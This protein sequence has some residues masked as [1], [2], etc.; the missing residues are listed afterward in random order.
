MCDLRTTTL[1]N[2][3]QGLFFVHYYLLYRVCKYIERQ[4][5]CICCCISYDGQIIQNTIM[6]KVGMSR[7]EISVTEYSTTEKPLRPRIFDVDKLTCQ[8]LELSS[9]TVAFLVKYNYLRTINCPCACKTEQYRF[10]TKWLQIR[11]YYSF[12]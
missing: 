3:I 1:R 11:V 2:S 5:T 12:L 7:V 4:N 9:A 8:F 6:L 10:A